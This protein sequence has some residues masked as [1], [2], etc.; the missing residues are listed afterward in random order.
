MKASKKSVESGRD[1]QGSPVRRVITMAW[2]IIISMLSFTAMDLADTLFVGWLGTVELA[3][4]GLAATV[5]FLLQCFFMGSLQGVSIVSSHAKGAE[6]LNRARRAAVTGLFLAVPAGLFV[7][8]TSFMDVWIFALM[9]GEAVV[10]AVASDYF[11]VRVWGVP[12]LFIMLAICNHY[13]G[14]GDTRTPMKINLVANGL[15]ILLTPMLIYGVGPFPALGVE[16]A[17]LATIGAQ[18]VGM[19]IALVHFGL[20]QRERMGFDLTVARDILRLGLP[21]GVRYVLGVMGFTVFTAFLAR[22]GT[23]ELAAHQI[24]IRVVSVSFL[25]GHGIGQAAAILTGQRVGARQFDAVNEVVW[26]ALRVAWTLMGALGVIFWFFPEAIS[27]IFIDDPRTITLAGQLLMVAAWFQLLDA[28]VMVL[29]QSL[30]GTGDTRF[31]MI[32]GVTTTW[33]I[34]LPTAWFLGFYLNLGAVGAWLAFIVELIVLNSIL[35]WRFR[36]GGWRTHS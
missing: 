12:F 5:L 32:V 21:M 33:T 25:P 14:L 19:T 9:G 15:N 13:Q 1:N 6:N 3:A 22:L 8:S 16:G 10:Q 26:A 17:A 28:T 18:F 2:P 7:V 11:S 4:V 35:I 23:V 34:M 27:Q 31:T 24:A 29:V 36:S 30:N 20:H